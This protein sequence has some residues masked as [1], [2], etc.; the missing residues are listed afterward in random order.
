MDFLTDTRIILSSSNFHPIGRNPFF[1]NSLQDVFS[2]EYV[3]PSTV[4][5]AGCG[6]LI[7]FHLFAFYLL[8][9][10][11]QRDPTLH[12]AV[13]NYQGSLLL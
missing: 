4:L 9:L 11:S 2:R 5:R 10:G 3:F 12:T 8:R 13:C 7:S 1:I 6:S